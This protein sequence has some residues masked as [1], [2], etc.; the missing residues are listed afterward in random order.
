MAHL[1]RS[2]Q[3]SAVMSAKSGGGKKMCAFLFFAISAFCILAGIFFDV[4]L[5]RTAPLKPNSSTGEV[6][7][8][9]KSS[10]RRYITGDAEL[11][12]NV[13]IETAFVFLLVGG[14][15]VREIKESPN[16]PATGQRP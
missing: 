16:K 8:L 1:E 10:P 9:G 6:V 2:A 5:R 4:H 12:T 13:C 3:I 11:L 7:P 14:R 15:L